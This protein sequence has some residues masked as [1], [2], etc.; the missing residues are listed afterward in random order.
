MTKVSRKGFVDKNGQK[1]VIVPNVPGATA[2]N[3]ASLDEE[4]N[5][6]DSGLAA[7]DVITNIKVEDLSELDNIIVPGVYHVVVYNESGNNQTR[8]A[9]ILFVRGLLKMGVYRLT[10]Y[11]FYRYSIMSRTKTATSPEWNVWEET[12]IEN[13]L[14]E[15]DDT[16]TATS[17]KLITSGGVKAALDKKVDKLLLIKMYH[18]DSDWSLTDLSNM[19][20]VI[21]ALALGTSVVELQIVIDYGGE[22]KTI[23]RTIGTFTKTL[24][25]T[26]D[27]ERPQDPTYKINITIFVSGYAF[28]GSAATDEYGSIEDTTDFEDHGELSQSNS[29]F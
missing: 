5:L 27:P 25:E 16:P 22:T 11:L 2:G 26:I 19:L 28:T 4:G 13:V 18:A 29:I 3:L 9:K 8:E 7:G 10:Q 23:Y 20:T 15:P 1:V 21:N 17:Q 6:R 14:T 24:V 12:N